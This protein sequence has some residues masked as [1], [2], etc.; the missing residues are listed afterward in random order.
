MFGSRT[1]RALGLWTIGVI[2]IALVS[3]SQ[4]AVM[5]QDR[6]STVEIDPNSSAGTYLWTVDGVNHL[7]QQWFWVRV[8][9][10]DGETSIDRLDLTYLNA[11]NGNRYPGAER[12]VM[13]YSDPAGRYEV[14]IDYTLKGGAMGSRTSDV[15]EQ[16]IV[17]NLTTKALDF[18]LY[19]YADFNLNGR[20]SDDSLVITGGNTALQHNGDSAYLSETVLTPLPTHYQAAL[21]PAILSSLQD[22]SPTTLSDANSAGPG[23]VAW[24]FQWDFQL[25]PNGSYIISKDKLIVPEPATVALL[26]LGCAGLI[27]RRRVRRTA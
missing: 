22:G 11:T 12:L 27:M 25:A 21:V 4:G 13:V 2:A 20:G 23:D 14:E 3:S 17:N 16:I 7:A 19:Q 9:S 6:N 18:H 26:S 8:G 5:L 15:Q 10:Q 1:T 24:G